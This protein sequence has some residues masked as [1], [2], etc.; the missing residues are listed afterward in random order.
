MDEGLRYG[1]D[2]RKGDDPATAVYVPDQE[3]G[4]HVP[5]LD[6]MGNHAVDKEGKLLFRKAGRDLTKAQKQA[7]ATQNNL[8]RSTSLKRRRDSSLGFPASKRLE[9]EK[10]QEGI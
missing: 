1:S 4:D 9:L 7:R 5:V 6:R 8:L 3:Y 2:R 10:K